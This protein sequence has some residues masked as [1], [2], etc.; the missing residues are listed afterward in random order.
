MVFNTSIQKKTALLLG[1]FVLAL[2]TANLL[3]SKITVLFGVNVS[4]AIFTYPFTFVV[5]DIIEEVHG[6]KT[7]RFFLLVGAL[8][9]IVLF[10]LTAISVSLPAAERFA[11]GAAA[12]NTTFKHS[13]R[14]ILASLTAFVISQS[15]D[16]WAFEFWKSRTSGRFL[17]LRNNLSTIASQGVDTF[18]FM[19][20]AF[21]QLTDR[22]TAGFVVELALTYWAIKILF[23]VIDTP[24][25][26]AGVQWLKKDLPEK[27][28]S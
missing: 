4:V 27:K 25:V 10:A 2:T 20:L 12:Y 15:H 23:A 11:E 5:T 8:S 17:W 19:F 24:V 28:G 18:I 3:G 6:K 1:I 21:Y 14:F 9:L 16:I 26:Y 22:F 13:L 7:S